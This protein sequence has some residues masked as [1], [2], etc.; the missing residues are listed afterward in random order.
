MRLVSAFMCSV[1]MAVCELAQSSAPANRPWMNTSLSPEK[2]AELLVK[3]MTLDEK[4]SQIHMRDMKE[5]PREVIGIERLGLPT[6]K[7]SNGPV[8]AGPGDS[9]EKQPATAFPSGLAVASTFDPRYAEIFGKTAGEEIASRGEHL[10]E[11]PGL[12]ITRVPQNGR[13]FEYFGE[14]PLLS[15]EMGIAETRGIQSAG[16]IAEPKHFD[17]NNQEHDRK[18]INEVIDERTLREIY[19]P[20]FEA[21]VKQANPGAIMCAYPGVNGQFSCENVHLLKDIL[22]GDWGFHGFV[23]SDYTATRSA[24]ANSTA[25][26]DLAMKPDHYSDEMKAAIQS[27]QVSEST[28][29]QMLIRRF[30]AM[31]RIG[32]FD[33]P[34]Q[35]HAILA[36]EN[37]LKART[38]AEA[39]AVLLKNESNQLPLDANKVHSIALVGPYAGAAHTGGG[40]SSQVVPLYTVTPE[41]GLHNAAPMVKVSYNDGADPA[42]AATLAKSADVAIVMVGNKDRENVDR[43]SLSL[44]DNQDQLI[45]AVSAANP[46]T[47]VVLKTGGPV[48]MPWLD[49]V[50]AVLEAWY[51]GEEDGNVVADLLFG[52]AN[53]SGKLP[54]SFPKTESETPAHTPEQYPGV[55][56]VS[57]YSEKLQVGYRWYDA[58]NVAPL[59]TFGF[60]LS[61]TT[62][63][64]SGLKVTSTAPATARVEVA[65]TNTGKRTG[66][67]VVQVYV[68]FPDSAGEPPRQIKGFARVSLAPGKTQ[69]VTIPLKQRAFSIWDTKANK[70][71]V[72]NGTYQIFAGD[73]SRNALLNATLKIQDPQGVTEP[74]PVVFHTATP[75]AGEPSAMQ[76]PTAQRQ[77]PLTTTGERQAPHPQTLEDAQKIID[78]DFHRLED[79]PQLHRYAAAN[80]ALPAPNEGEDRVVFMGDSIT[81]GWKLP[82]YFPGKEYV[83]RGISGQTTPQM[84]IR[85]RPDVIELQ[86]KVV[87][88]LAGTNDIAGNTGPMTVEQIE[89]N[90]AS[91]ADLAAAHNIKVIFESVLP[92]HDRGIHGPQTPRRS[93]ENINALNNWLKKYCADHHLI[94]LDYYSHMLGPDGMLRTELSNDGLHPNA[95]GYKVMARLAEAA[96]EQALGQ[97]R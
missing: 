79:W 78:R 66:A 1:L 67:D 58:N 24:V 22:R 69:R 5:F 23:Q 19:L 18:T 42:A 73:S 86:P 96:I 37:G 15:G 13:N 95:E 43:P 16:V 47:I 48:L 50:P 30:A 4:I 71:T 83:N 60:G 84:L 25:G 62:F 31:F 27:G 85:M 94:Y 53:P 39:G 90:Y 80:A 72:F 54:M 26:E 51:P 36:K 2:R 75:I 97:K 52:K 11:A 7:I 76:A 57:T 44:P 29:D 35:P 61:Y 46:H 81:D 40:G 17:A 12:N 93:P 77:V 9:R 88:I 3:A 68:G 10:L 33:Y 82:E 56:G 87:I 14:D 38:I 21:T 34:P 64:V 45:S 89:R 28:L 49:T 41:E 55:N 92:V 65:V 20:A 32:W 70:W 63:K 6:F 59:F 74:G 8:G 91:M